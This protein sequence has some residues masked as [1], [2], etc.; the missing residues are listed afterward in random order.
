VEYLPN[1]IFLQKAQPNPESVIQTLSFA[2]IGGSGYDRCDGE[3]LVSDHI[4]SIGYGYDINICIGVD[5]EA[6]VTIAITK[7]DGSK[8]LETGRHQDLVHKPNSA[9]LVPGPDYYCIDPMHLLLPGRYQISVSFNNT[10]F[11]NYFE[12]QPPYWKTGPNIFIGNSCEGSI[13]RAGESTFIFYDNFQPNETIVVTLYRVSEKKLSETHSPVEDTVTLESAI[14]EIGMWTTNMDNNGRLVEYIEAPKLLGPDTYL[15]VTVGNRRDILDLG[16]GG[17]G[18]ERRRS[19]KGIKLEATALLYFESKQ[20]EAD[21]NTLVTSVLTMASSLTSGHFLNL[22]TLVNIPVGE[23][24]MGSASGTDPFAEKI[25]RPQHTVYVSDFWIQRTEVNNARYTE[26]VSTGACSPPLD[27]R[28]NNDDYYWGRPVVNVTYAQAQA[29]CTWAGGRLPTEAEW[30][31]A[32]RYPDGRLY[33]WGNAKPTT[34]LANYNYPTGDTRVVTA[35][36]DGATSLGIVNMAGNVWEWVADWYAPDYYSVSPDKDPT[37]PA[38]GKERVVRGGS[39]RSEPQFLR[40]TNRF[41]SDPNKGGMG[42]GFR[43]VTTTAP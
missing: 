39:Y 13:V 32:A 7:P 33:P 25:E 22:S 1:D 43:C 20:A 8:L 42:I 31:K 27:S 6:P 28:P 35:Y 30:E 38:T 5:D 34:I 26:C 21:V 24:K 16:D 41:S 2:P 29:Y 9:N 11:T 19:L 14:E 18:I 23:F 3:D 37:G 15:L 12:P 17:D 4:A 40:T 36:P 10:I